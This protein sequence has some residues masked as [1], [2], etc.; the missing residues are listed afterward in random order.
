M[1]KPKL[2]RDT[3]ICI[4]RRNG[5]SLVPVSPSD[6]DMI[7]ELTSTTDIE[8]TFTNRRSLP[9]LRSYWA[10]LQEVI[11]ATECYPTAEK[12]H[13]E[14]KMEMG[15]T[16][17]GKRFDGTIHTYPDSVALSKMDAVE[18]TGFYRR[19]ERLIAQVFGYAREEKP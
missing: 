5:L 6:A 8:V 16:T 13:D 18:F 17:T 14:L 15:Y 19:A 12:L 7:M 1:G 11:D 9:Q 4:V 10:F 3:R 2:D